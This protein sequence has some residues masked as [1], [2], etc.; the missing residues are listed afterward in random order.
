MTLANLKK[1]HA[2]LK[3]LASGEFTERDFDFTI[4]ASDNPFGKKG[5]AGRMSMGD[6]NTARRNLIKQDA[7]RTLNLF[8][9]KYPEFVSVPEKVVQTKP[10]EKKDAK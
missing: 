4:K 2:W 8:E 1:H 5:E 3:Y 10:K 7:Q 6:F 9:T